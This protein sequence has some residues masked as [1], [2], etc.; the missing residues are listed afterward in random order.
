VAPEACSVATQRYPL[1]RPLYLYVLPNA[2]QYAR[3]FAAFARSPDGQQIAARV[4]FVSQEP[5]FDCPGGGTNISLYFDIGSST[6]R[7]ELNSQA[8][9]NLQGLIASHP[10]GGLVLSGFADNSGSEG[11]SPAVRRRNNLKLSNDRAEAVKDYLEQRGAVVG[12]VMAFG[13]ESPLGDNRTEDGRQKNR[14]VDVSLAG[15]TSHSR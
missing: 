14:R 5:R 3:E 7:G 1:A 9:N 8:L 13:E 4:G 12:R 2:S 10:Q 11:A 15:A 6:I